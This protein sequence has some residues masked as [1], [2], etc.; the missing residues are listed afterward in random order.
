MLWRPQISSVFLLAA[1][2][3]FS[4]ESHPK[5]LAAGLPQRLVELCHEEEHYQANGSTCWPGDDSSSDTDE[6]GDEVVRTL[7][8]H[9]HSGELSPCG[10]TANGAASPLSRKAS[11]SDSKDLTDVPSRCL[12][13][14]MSDQLTEALA[15]PSTCPATSLG[16]SCAMAL[17]GLSHNEA[18]HATLLEV[19][20]VEVLA[21]MMKHKEQ[22]PAQRIN[23]AMAV[24]ILV[25][26]F[27]LV[28]NWLRVCTAARLRKC[29]L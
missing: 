22:A 20:A 1:M 23:A 19:G 8:A 4:V 12:G 17:R 6:E 26:G 21:S 5:V 10:S 14:C 11:R 15:A 16:M 24:A 3:S 29:Q 27:G 9:Q 2:I 7:M 13:R 25:G 18:C 28:V